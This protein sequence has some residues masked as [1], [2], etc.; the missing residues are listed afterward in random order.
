VSTSQ[1]VCARD[2]IPLSGTFYGF[3]HALGGNTGAILSHRRHKPVPV[4]RTDYDRAFSLHTP[5]EEARALCARF[6]E[7]D[8]EIN[9]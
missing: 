3:R 5:L 6:R 7:A 2:G 1:F 8:K 4:L 9:G